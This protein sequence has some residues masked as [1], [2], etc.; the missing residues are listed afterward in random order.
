MENYQRRRSPFLILTMI[1]VLILTFPGCRM[2][3]TIQP[4]ERGV[5]F[6]PL[7]SGLDKD[8]VLKPGLKVIAPGN[9]LIIYSVKEQQ[10][11]HI[12]DVLDK[13]GILLRYD[14]SVRFNPIPEKIGYLHESYGPEY[15]EKLIKPEVRSS[16]R[17]VAGQYS[18]EEIYSTK[19]K[20]MEDRIV[21]E[22]DSILK[23]NFVE[24]RAVLMRINKPPTEIQAVID[25]KLN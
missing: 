7:T 25:T 5:I 3:Q 4:D 9:T 12:I 11:D 16:V 15:V 6:K 24:M 14:V 20:E 1:F 22:T 10:I 8:H 17:K 18:A 2:F 21:K 23:Q 13:N 19:R